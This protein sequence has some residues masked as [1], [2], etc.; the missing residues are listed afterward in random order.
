MEEEEEGLPLFLLWFCS[1]AVCLQL[2][3]Y[4]RQTVWHPQAEEMPDSPA[5]FGQT[6][7][8]ENPFI[9]QRNTAVRAEKNKNTPL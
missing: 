7:R 5:A 4:K 3:H 8:W 9:W 2:A 6:E 1:S